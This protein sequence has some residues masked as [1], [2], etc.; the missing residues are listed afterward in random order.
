[1]KCAC[2]VSAT[3]RA[4]LVLPVPGGPQRMTDCSRSRSMASRSGLPGAS[5]FC[6]PDVLVE[7]ARAACAP[8]A[9]C[10]RRRRRPGA[11]RRRTGAGRSW[12][13]GAA[14]RCRCASNR[15]TPAATATLSDSTGACIG[16]RTRTSAAA[17]ASS[18]RP[19]PS[20]PTSSSTGP[21]SRRRTGPGPPAGVVATTRHAAP[22]SLGAGR[23]DVRP[24]VQR[25]PQGAAHRAAQRL[26][27]ERVR[28]A[29]GHNAPVAPAASAA[30]RMA[31]TFP[32][33]WTPATHDGQGRRR[34]PDASGRRRRA[35]RAMATMPG[36]R[37][38]GAGGLH[39]GIRRPV[40][41]RHR[42]ARAAGTARRP[43]RLPASFAPTQ[44]RRHGD[45]GARAPR[46]PGARRPAAPR[47]R[48][49]DGG[50]R[51]PGTS[52][53]WGSGGW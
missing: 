48:R 38:H 30:R 8:P 1:M 7:R 25:Q 24:V 13:S 37:P 43:R 6:W 10:G 50:A 49:P 2:V 12:P 28:R 5:R 17:T 23:A 20:P 31:P 39:G 11:R 34:R 27:A 4:R 33:S 22:P 15:M 18:G 40:H 44:R 36:G 21:R 52:G 45:A 16:I 32:G 41:R 35:S 47:R 46:R 42:P 19:A 53:R 26:P 51:G 29:L 3:R 9:A 14:R